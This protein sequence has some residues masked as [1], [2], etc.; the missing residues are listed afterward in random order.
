MVA[1]HDRR[2]AWRSRVVDVDRG[3]AMGTGTKVAES[4]DILG[5]AKRQVAGKDERRLQGCRIQELNT[6]GN[7]RADPFRPTG[8]VNTGDMEVANR[9]GHAV[10]FRSRDHDYG[11]DPCAKKHLRLPP[12]QRHAFPLFKQLGFTLHPP[13]GTGGK[14]D[15]AYR[16]RFHAPSVDTGPSTASDQTE[17]RPITSCTAR[18]RSFP[19]NGFGRIVQ[20]SSGSG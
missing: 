8:V 9:I 12:H 16:G 2:C 11:P 18:L 10:V 15:C 6:K 13:A 14:E 20:C 1:T 17:V 7:G 5:L 4:H 3:A 19:L